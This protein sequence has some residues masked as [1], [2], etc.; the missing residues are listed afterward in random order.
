MEYRRRLE[1]NTRRE[2]H[3]RNMEYRIENLILK[4]YLS[5][6]IGLQNIVSAFYITIEEDTGRVR[7]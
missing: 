6:G 2:R 4:Y 7:N 3:E 1:S 5:L